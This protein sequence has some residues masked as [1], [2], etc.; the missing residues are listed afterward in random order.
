MDLNIDEVLSDFKALLSGIDFSSY[1]PN[2]PEFMSAL[3]AGLMWQLLCELKRNGSEID[4]NYKSR[5][6]RDEISE[7]LHGA[8]KYLQKFMDSNDIAY[9]EMAKDELKHAE[10]LIKKANAKLPGGEEKAKLKE[11][12]VKLKELSEMIVR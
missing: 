8:K 12:E 4:A 1:N 7:E 6:E 2:S 3:N 9:K 5:M 11:Y 10:T